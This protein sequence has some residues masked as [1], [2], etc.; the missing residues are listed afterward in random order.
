MYSY[1]AVYLVRRP[2]LVPLQY[3]PRYDPLNYPNLAQPLY[4]LL[5]AFCDHVN[6]FSNLIILLRTL[7]S[8][9][10]MDK[11]KKKNSVTL[12]LVNIWHVTFM[13]KSCAS[14]IDR[15]PHTLHHCLQYAIKHS[16]TIRLKRKLLKSTSTDYAVN[17]IT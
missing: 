2:W 6:H 13:S 8:T 5:T 3:D 15:Q 14:L 9:W 4:C 10:L 12:Q 1:T 11:V 17:K 7:N 16:L